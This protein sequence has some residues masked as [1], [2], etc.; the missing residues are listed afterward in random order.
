MTTRNNKGYVKYRPGTLLYEASLKLFTQVVYAERDKDDEQEPVVGV[1]ITRPMPN[2]WDAVIHYEGEETDD[3]RKWHERFKMFN[4]PLLYI[5][6]PSEAMGH[7]SYLES[8]LEEYAFVSRSILWPTL[9]YAKGHS[10]S[11]WRT[12]ASAK[13]IQA[14]DKQLH[15]H[16]IAKKASPDYEIYESI[17][18]IRQNRGRI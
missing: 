14:V 8:P 18:R 4:K 15:V 7:L 10:G 9:Y 13:Y 5:P 1:Y 11:T 2:T 3:I 12:F 16:R 17:K 6:Y